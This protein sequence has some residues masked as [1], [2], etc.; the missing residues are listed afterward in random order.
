M[1]LIVQAGGA[2]ERLDH[3]LQ[4]ELP[5]YSRA[6]LQ[7][8]IKE[9][10][11]L[12][13]A[14]KAKA[15]ALLRAGQLIEVHPA[16]PEPLRAFAEDLPLRVLYE[17]ASVLAVDKPSGM[18]VHIGAGVRSGTVVNA[19]LHRFASLSNEGGPLRPGIVH[20]I[21]KDTSGVLLVAR[22]DASH[23]AL[24]AQFAGRTVEKTYLALVEGRV[25]S[26]QGRVAAPI[27]RDP[28]HRIRMTCR[29]G[30]GRAAL[31]EYR[32]RRRFERHTLLEVKIHTGR[33]HQIRVHMA[34]AGHPVAGD[35]LY[36][37]RAAEPGRQFLHAWRIAFTSP[38]SGDRVTVEAPLPPD[39]ESWLTRPL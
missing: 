39:L 23:R 38:G 36:G 3:Y 5:A 37:A 16:E 17:D 27:E 25:A 32:V 33:T 4:R 8:W 9:E 10:R 7:E 11:V 13:D 26:E 6:R 30:K 22:N 1:E 21:D 28:V 24:A 35:T 31:T 20:R 18:V 34:S 29:T 14:K 19:L 15:S 2:G 12:V